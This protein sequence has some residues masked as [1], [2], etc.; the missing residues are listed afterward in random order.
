[1]SENLWCGADDSNHAGT[2]KGEFIVVT[3]STLKEDSIVKPF[4]NHRQRDETNLWLE[5]QRRDFRFTLLTREDYRHRG[6]NVPKIAPFIVA[7]YLREKKEAYKQVNLYLDGWLNGE[8]KR[9]IREIISA[10][11]IERVVVDNFT[12][13]GKNKFQKRHFCPELV[14][15]A[16]NLAHMLFRYDGPIEELLNDSRL[17]PFESL[18][19][20]AHE[21]GYCL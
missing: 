16:D 4:P 21:K 18:Q 12:K 15:R 11:G 5:N 7:Y 20:I 1:M 9:F 2:T 6:D 8:T 14:Y 10:E 17:V 3:F 19:K 13:K